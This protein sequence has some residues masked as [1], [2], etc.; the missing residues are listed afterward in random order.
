M[1]K[2][3]IEGKYYCGAVRFSIQDRP[4]GLV[5]CDHPVRVHEFTNLSI[6]ANSG[7]MDLHT[8]MGLK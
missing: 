2:E 4:K 3:L 8:K 7:N 6:L 1:N 5:N